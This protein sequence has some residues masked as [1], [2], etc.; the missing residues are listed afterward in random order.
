MMVDLRIILQRHTNLNITW[1]TLTDLIN[2]SA[3]VFD[4]ALGN[5]SQRILTLKST[6]RP[7]LNMNMLF[8]G[9]NSKS[10]STCRSHHEKYLVFI[11][12]GIYKTISSTNRKC[13]LFLKN[14][15]RQYSKY[16]PLTCWG[17]FTCSILASIVTILGKHCDNTYKYW[18][19]VWKSVHLQV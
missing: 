9:I 10:S 11:S 14:T 17:L 6:I 19:N 7:S 5:T 1:N 18:A 12:I 8:Q 13:T 16:S 3:T 15:S 2:F 4:A